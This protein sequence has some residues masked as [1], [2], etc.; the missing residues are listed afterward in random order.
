VERMKPGQQA[1][2][3]LAGDDRAALAASPQLEGFA[4]RGVEVLLLTDPVDAFWPE[5]LSSF[6]DKPLRSVTQG[7]ADLS[8]LPPPEA[9]AN[10]APAVDVTAL[11]P[12]LKAAL[13]EA[14]DDVR[15]TDRLTSSAAVLTAATHGPDLQLQRL[16][17][18]SGRA[19]PEQA[20]ILDINPRHPLV[21]ALAAKVARGEDVAEQAETLL[22]LARVQ[23]GEAPRDPAAFARRVAVA[24]AK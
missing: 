14:V 15:P 8:L 19:L 5:R 6:N 7:A 2:Y 12:A 4:A 20:P 21:A 10:A 24:L 23:D 9:D 22:D 11:V 16:M 3:F 18:R 17:R 1:I 13:G